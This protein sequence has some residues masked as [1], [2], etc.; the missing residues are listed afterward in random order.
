MYDTTPSLN[1]MSPVSNIPHLTDLD[2]DLNMPSDH[3]FNYYSPH[4]FHSNHDIIEC[5]SNPQSF[6][7]LNCNIR[8]L[9]ANYD[10][11]LQ[12]LSELDFSFSLIG[13]SE[14]K[15]KVDNDYVA[16]VNICGYNFI[17][18]PS[19]SNAGG[20]RFYIKN[21]FNYVI[22]SE[23]TLSDSN[24]E[25]LWIEIQL[26]GQ[27]NIICAV[28]Y[29]HP[30][31]NLDN[32]M[33]YVN[34]TI[35]KIHHENKQ[36]LI[37]GDFNIDL[38]RID[39]H[40]DSENFIN[41]L[42]SFCF[43]PQIIQP[44]RITSHSATLIDNIFFNSIEHFI[45]SGNIVY[46]LTDH[47]PNFIIFNKFA[48]LPSNVKIYKR[49]YSRLDEKALIDEVQSVNWYTVFASTSDPTSMFDKFYSE[50]SEIVDGHIPIKQ[51]STK[52]LKFRSKP[53]ITPALKVSIHIKN[54]LYE[55]FLKTNS[56]Y[57]HSKF[58]YYRNRINHLLKVSKSQ[59]YNQY[60]LDDIKD[61]KR[62]WNDIKQIIHFKPKTSHKAVKI[63]NENIEMTNPYMIANAFNNYFASVG[64]NLANEI[65]N[66]GKSPLDYLK[67]SSPD[68]FFISPITSAEIEIEISKLKTG[69]ATGPFSIPISVL[70]ILKTVIAKPLEILF[71]T[72][73]SSGIVPTKFKQASV[74]PVYKTKSPTSLCNYRP[75]SLL[76]ISNKLL[77]K[78]MYKKL[79]DFL[80][81]KKVLFKKQFGFRENHS[82]D[83]AILSIIHNIQLAIDERDFSCGI[84]LD[85]SKAFDTVN[86]KILIDKLEH[87][88]I[89]GLAKDWFISYLDNRQQTVTINNNTSSS[90]SISCGVPQGSV[91][92]PL[93]FLIYINDFHLCSDIFDFHLFAD[94]ANL[95]YGHKNLSTMQSIINTELTNVHNWL[96]VNRLSLNIEKSNFVIF[97]PPQKTISYNLE[98]IINDKHLNQENCIKYLGIFIDSNLN[99]KSQIKSII[100]KIKR[101]IGVLSKIRYYVDTAILISLYYALI[102]PFLIY[103][104]I[105]WG[106]TYP[107]TLQ[108][109]YVSQKKVMRIITFSKFDEHSSP[110]IKSLNIIK[111]FDLV[112]LSIA[113][114]MFKFKKKLLPSIFNTLFITVNEVHNYNTCKIR[115]K[116]VF[117]FA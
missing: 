6:S 15:L 35:E 55:K 19:I 57:Y 44:T 61:S 71:N 45:I 76:S 3:N 99:W 110:I 58:K 51:L 47:L 2:V 9:A 8:S 40:S 101:S 22:R 79:L 41:T 66:L 96:C 70:K 28:L 33:N 75:I 23:F 95:F 113:I 62:V 98:L 38:L 25:A 68:S 78:L 46:D 69:K 16:N 97:H 56:L 31:G 60:F 34:S 14:T 88:G 73:F 26:V 103:G 50:I 93:L 116:A 43:Q 72:S 54:K 1:I 80:E 81:K 115:C 84:F 111:L 12:M 42:G 67:S 24:Y 39:D 49:D 10:N 83:H 11:L 92:G 18:E 117:L 37:M 102:Y 27:S 77:E 52:E 53:W 36:C 112:T 87:Y 5:S 59:Y 4:D 30:N 89:R 32:F 104:I 114:F 20:V 17:S 108:P 85:F 109:L 29:R 65:P 82:T 90:I 63:I 107:T 106:N 48:S 94:Y 21:N 74:V 7:A 64:N 105:A 100:K 86:H 91:L 13:L